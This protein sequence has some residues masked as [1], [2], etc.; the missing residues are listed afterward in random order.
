LRCQM[1]VFLMRFPGCFCHVFAILSLNI[2][3]TGQGS[4]TMQRL[5]LTRSGESIGR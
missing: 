2:Q 1:S 5:N 4:A 3:L